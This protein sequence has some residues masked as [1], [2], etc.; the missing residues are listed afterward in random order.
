MQNFQFPSSP[1]AETFEKLQYSRFSVPA[2]E[3]GPAPGFLQA[4]RTW[5]GAYLVVSD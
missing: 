3:R 1:L 4:E 5:R 2:P